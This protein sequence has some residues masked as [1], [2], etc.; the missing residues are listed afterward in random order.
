MKPF[1]HLHLHT[2]FSNIISIPEVV[3]R[4]EQYIE[5]AVA[6]GAPAVCFT[7]HG[8]VLSWVAKKMATN[9]AGLKYIHGIEAYVTEGLDEKVRD[10]YHVVL[11]AKNYKGVKE[12]NTL[13]SQSFIGKG[14]KGAENAHY[15]YSPRISFEELKNTSDNI[16]ILTAC[17]AS[18]VWRHYKNNEAEPLKEWLDFLVSN[19]HRVWLEVQPHDNP[20]QIKYNA[21]LKSLAKSQGMNLVATNDVHALDQESNRVRKILMKSKNI[22]FE[23]DDD[24]ETWWKNRDEMS[25]SFLDQ[26]VFNKDEIEKMLD[27]SLNIVDMIEDF[28]FDMSFK[29]P[30]LYDDPEGRFKKL[31][32]E[33]YKNKGFDNLPTEEQKIY[34]QRIDK[35]LRVYR[36]LKSIDFMLLMEYIDRS[37]RDNGHHPGYARGSVAGSVIAYLLDIIE[38]DPI[39]E[40]LN[41]ERFMNEDRVNL[42]DIDTDFF[43]TDRDW[44]TEFLLTNDKFNCSAIVT[45]N[46]LGVKGA[47]KD[48]GRAMGYDA[49][50]MNFLTKSLPQ[51]EKKKT[52]IPQS[53]REKYPELVDVAE[54]VIGVI[55]SIGRHAGG[56]IVTTRPLEEELG[57]IHVKDSSY[58]VSAVAMKEVEKLYYVKMDILGL[59]N[60]GLINKTCELANIERATPESDYIDFR[61][62]DVVKDMAK[63][64]TAIFQFEGQRAQK[65]LSIMFSD[66]TIDRMK[67]NGINVDPINQ[68]ALLNAAMRPGAASVIDDITNGVVK[69]NGHKALNRLLRDT[70]GYLIYQESQIQFLVEFCGRTPAQADLVRRAIGHKEPEVLAVEI[71]KIK[72]EFVETM[73][74]KFHDDREHAEEIVEDFIQIFQDASDYSFSRNHSIPYS[75]IG[76]ISAWLRWY[77]PL[78]FCTAGLQIWKDDQEKTNKLIDYAASRGISIE[79]QKFRYSKGDYFFDKETNT[80]YLGTA[81]IKDNNGQCGDMLYALK[82]RQFGTFT[83]FLLAI[84]DETT[85]IDKVK[86]EKFTLK[87]IFSMSEDEV[88]QLDK[89]LAKARKGEDDTVSMEQD[90]LPIN[91]TKLLSLVRLNYF[92]EFGKNKK[93]EAI[94]NEFDKSYKPKNKT[95]KG[96]RQKYLDLLEYE[97]AAENESFSLLEQCEHELYYTGR[98]TAVSDKIPARYAFVTKI[99][100]EGKTRVTAEVYI[101]KKGVT[102]IVKTGTRVYRNVPFAEGDLIEVLSAETKPKMTK[103]D[104]T[105]QKHPT[106]KELWIKDLKR[107]RKKENK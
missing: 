61:D 32:L 23:N 36:K 33:G 39:K 19:K 72:T 64:T 14:D 85:I 84:R 55:T 87:D 102:A 6:E 8:S 26:G 99:I 15:Y 12:I 96:K 68:L 95:F 50:E 44:V 13:S 56:Y 40:D 37:A 21:L 51:D 16:L 59:D 47:I 81:S 9:K 73:V 88:K 93:L 63:D 101:L 52:Y 104:G 71:P 105:W 18:P 30:Q 70:L 67:A 58:P 53:V 83:D 1:V 54:K 11:L 57:T 3:T 79:S 41:F 75:Y 66:R 92:S 80:I 86:D 49:A 74:E 38:V 82:E 29:Y 46:T 22:N 89:Q 42:S 90:S 43:S 45:Y 98:V 106:E 4:P 103:I 65:L 60:I 100:N 97:K 62:L 91:K 69:D 28:E 76:Y 78:E 31:I 24:F 2:T 34:Q 7:E 35:E 48:I 5:R 10:N 27:E 20:E 107:I 17:L 77:Y 25:D 94:F